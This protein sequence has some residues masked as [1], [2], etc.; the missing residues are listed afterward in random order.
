MAVTILTPAHSGKE[1]LLP[2]PVVPPSSCSR[3]P[4]PVHERSDLANPPPATLLA[5]AS[6]FPRDVLDVDDAT[7]YAQSLSCVNDEQRLK[8]AK[9][10]RRTGVESR[11]SVLAKTDNRGR[12]RLD[13]YDPLQPDGSGRGAGDILSA[14]DDGGS[15]AVQTMPPPVARAAAT[16]R[17]PTTADR[18][19]RYGVEAARLAMR[20]A[21]QAI[22]RSGRPASAITHLVTV[23]CTGFL[24]PGIDI[25]LIEGLDLSPQTQRVNVGFMGCHGLINGLRV[26]RDIVAADHR[27]TVLV[28]SVELCS[29]H[30][31]YGYD[32][33]RIV[34]GAIFA[35][36]SSSAVV[37]RTGDSNRSTSGVGQLGDGGSCLIPGSRDAMTWRIGDH[38]FEMTLE[39]TVPSLIEHHLSGFLCPWLASR[40]LDIE[41]IGGWAV[42]PG[43]T[44]ILGAVESALNLTPDDLIV[45]YDVLRHHGNMSSATLGVILG[46]FAQNDVPRPWAMLG[47]GPGLEVELLLVR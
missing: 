36:G 2:P 25:D 46:R 3:R 47:F 45:S 1:N 21:C 10:Y 38:G 41:S 32:A 5:V 42:H 6:S 18:N 31:Q 40:D 27:A 44:R 20:S 33:H 28:V 9:L 11:G 35:D 17:G 39:A 29:L 23:S 19:N 4:I 16:S 7:E 22:E 15:V 26:A 43:G 24:A 37:G 13:F 34:S 14:D 8:V 12:V 30:Y